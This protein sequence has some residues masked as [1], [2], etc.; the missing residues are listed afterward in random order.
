MAYI[1]VRHVFYVPAFRLLSIFSRSFL[2]IVEKELLRMAFHQFEIGG[3]SVTD[4]NR[5]SLAPL[6][7][8]ARACQLTRQPVNY[9]A[10][11][12]LAIRCSI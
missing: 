11:W 3:S 5:D 6:A 10:C 8:I 4:V 12:S 2:V 1:L 9:P 7:C